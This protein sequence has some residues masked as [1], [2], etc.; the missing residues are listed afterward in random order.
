MENFT[1]YQKGKSETARKIIEYIQSLPDDNKGTLIS[2]KG[3]KGSLINWIFK[4]FAPN[5][6]DEVEDYE[7]PSLWPVPEMRQDITKDI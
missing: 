7:H 3:T 4:N 6:A 1:A 2:Q 5:M